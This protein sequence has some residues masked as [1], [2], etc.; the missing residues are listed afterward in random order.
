MDSNA[1]QPA[2][3][4]T[5]TQPSPATPPPAE[6]AAPA[7]PAQPAPTTPPPAAPATPP[8][9]PTTPTPEH[10]SSKLGL[11]LGVLAAVVVVIGGVMLYSFY[12]NKSASSLYQNA[13]KTQS[14]VSVTPSPMPSPTMGAVKSG[15]ARLD[16]QSGAVDASMDS[17]N[18]D[19]KSV[20]AGLS[21]QQGNLN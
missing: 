20:D 15:D 4:Q 1:Q 3:A 14:Q 5:G 6:A 11:L 7:A 17:L 19:I 18:T 21:D 2:P 13:Y 9:D 12:Q 16:Q 8:A 10:K